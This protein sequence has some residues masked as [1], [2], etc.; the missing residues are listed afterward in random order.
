MAYV[1]GHYKADT[2][3]LF[4]IGKGTGDRAWQHRSR[5][6]HWVSVV[7]KHGLVVKV[8]EDGLTDDIAYNRERELIAEVGLDALVNMTEGG[9][10]FTSAI[11][12][13][14]W[15]TED[16]KQKQRNGIRTK[17][18]D[19]A[20]R[21][22]HANRQSQKKN[23]P[24]FREK[25][26]QAFEERCNTPEWRQ[27]QKT[28]AALKRNNPVFSKKMTAIANRRKPCPNGCGKEMNGGNLTRHV[29]TCRGI[30]D[31]KS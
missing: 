25:C 1:Y 7:K 4:Y 30:P 31:T 18:Q 26:K 9:D 17:F 24:V 11:A 10:G 3:E 23:N 21:Q 5:N 29:P 12:K 8:L 22:S 28:A 27:N 16:F 13:Q 20:F 2:G 6:A 14:L 19:E 15:Q